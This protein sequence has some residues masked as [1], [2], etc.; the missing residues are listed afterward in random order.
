MNQVEKKAVKRIH[1][2]LDTLIINDPLSAKE[3]IRLKGEIDT[4]GVGSKRVIPMFED[5]WYYTYEA[6]DRSETLI[7]LGE[8]LGVA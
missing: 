3:F 8:E 2:L 7:E 5:I 6:K 1:N 4:Y